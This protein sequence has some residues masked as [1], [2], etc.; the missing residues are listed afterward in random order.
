LV[1]DVF[2]ASLGSEY[3]E[4]LWRQKL[5]LGVTLRFVELNLGINFEAP[6]FADSFRGKGM[7]FLLG[8]SAGF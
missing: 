7:G 6:D 5:A 1:W 8:I 3:R 2:S 4:R